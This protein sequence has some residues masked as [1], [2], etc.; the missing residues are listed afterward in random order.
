M[1]DL[2]RL[3]EL[4]RFPLASMGARI[5]QLAGVCGPLGRTG[6]ACGRVRSG[7]RQCGGVGW[8]K[9]PWLRLPRAQVSKSTI[10]NVYA[11]KLKQ[12]ETFLGFIV[13]GSAGLLFGVS[14]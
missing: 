12:R 8:P 9:L 4:G 1:G 10:C 13:G 5:P 3:F 14:S 2:P 7:P 6:C 11:R